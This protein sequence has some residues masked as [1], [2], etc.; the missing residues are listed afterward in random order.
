MNKQEV[1]VI[2]DWWHFV[3]KNTE[4]NIEK[5]SSDRYEV[6]AFVSFKTL[7]QAKEAA[8]LIYNHLN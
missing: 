5:Y 2:K 4:I 6:R 3:D 1:K 8:E 7:K